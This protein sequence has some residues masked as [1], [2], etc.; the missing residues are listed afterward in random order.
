[1]H[2]TTEYT[3]FD[4]NDM[5]IELLSSSKRSILDK[6]I[7]EPKFYTIIT[8][9]ELNSSFTSY[10]IE[11]GVI[12]LINN[13]VVTIKKTRTRYSKLLQLYNSVKP[14]VPDPKFPIFPPKKL[15]K[16]N[17]VETAEYRLNA[18]NNFVRILNQFSGILSN[19][20][21]KSIFYR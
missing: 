2:K 3:N 8:G 10:I 17:T 18:M 9:Y 15:W 7:I 6:S 11:Y 12:N 4:D 16:N 21:F 20:Y 14:I 13:K 5:E 1:M 19:T